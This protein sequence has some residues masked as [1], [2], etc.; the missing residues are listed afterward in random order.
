MKTTLA[1]IAT[2]AAVLM[3]AG[4]TYAG[5]VP[6]TTTLPPQSTNAATPAIP[7][8]DGTPATP[9]VPGNPVARAAIARARLMHEEHG[10]SDQYAD[11]DQDTVTRPT[12]TRP[13][14]TRPQIMR[15]QI[16]RPTI[17]RP[18]MQ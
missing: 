4:P 8:T 5:Q 6:T 18:S 7:G 1:M 12:M 11:T 14:I 3:L 13:T 16:E 10:V 9:A 17:E 2:T 15:P